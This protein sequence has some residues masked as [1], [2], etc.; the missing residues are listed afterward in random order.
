MKIARG[1]REHTKSSYPVITIGNF[2]GHHRGHR[3]LL[4]SV[5][6][7]AS[8]H[9]GTA[10]VLT[11]DPHPVKVLA[12]EVQLK[13]LTT[14]EE[15]LARFQEA[16]IQEVIYLTFDRVLA[17]MT[18]E[19]FVFKILRDGIGT[20]ELFVGE[21]FAF[22]KGRS[23]R[24]E[25][26]MR[27]GERAGFLTH[28]VAP[29]RI[30]GEVVSSSRIRAQIQK[31]DVRNAR[32]CLGRHYA[33]PGRVIA[34]ERRGQAIGWPTANLRLPEDRVIPADG[35]YA[36]VVLWK[37][38]RYDSVSYIG[39]RPTFGAG[40]RLLEVHVFDTEVD[41]YDEELVVEFVERLR[42]D[43]AFPS[44]DALAAQIELDVAQARNVLRGGGANQG[45]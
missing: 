16:R 24:V 38:D 35:I 3:A 4:Q 13:F 25:D 41:L 8:H 44:P 2:D 27:L 23:G 26:L 18:P 42:G 12:P 6:D 7:K 36:T 14:K 22:G 1:L 45:L 9:H 39:V 19:E 5:V 28:A 15:K 21:H 33:V 11:F 43:Q 40:E 29:F 31:G 37:G 30:D 32:R 17:S 10:T 20:R 34:G